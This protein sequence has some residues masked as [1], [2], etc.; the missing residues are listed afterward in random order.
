[1]NQAGYP[2]RMPKAFDLGIPALEGDIERVEVALKESV[3]TDDPF[4]TEVASHL[5]NAGGKRLR[6]TLA[7]CAA[8][9]APGTGMGGNASESVVNGAVAAEL[10]HLGSLYHDDVIDEATTRRGVQSVNARWSNIVAIL[11]GDFLLAR[12]SEIAASL[13]S[14]VAGLLAGTIGELCKGQMHELQYLFNIERSPDA[15]FSAIAGKTAALMASS[16]RIGGMA[17]GLPED[18]I[19]ALST[20][21]YHT[22]IVFQIV[23]DVL[24]LTASADELGK[25]T[26]NDLIEGIYTLPVIDALGEVP[27]LR[28][29]LGS[30]L[31]SGDAEK[32]RAL[33][34]ANGSIG[35]ALA[36]GESHAVQA[37]AALGSADLDPTAVEALSKL[38]QMML[39]RAQVSA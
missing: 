3:R 32:A 6:P 2:R 8:Y 22:G 1:M 13:G 39:T 35:N 29:L 31:A 9:A 27:G 33:V 4:L 10:V 18:S 12:A 19:D 23:D 21:G 30:R 16:C 7:L 5:I 15:Y 25:P 17:G 20:F 24:D 28:E 26:C 34:T 36:V 14:E 38:P 11:T 37:V